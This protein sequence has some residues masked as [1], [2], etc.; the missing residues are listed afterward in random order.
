MRAQTLEDPCTLLFVFVCLGLFV[1]LLHIL[2]SVPSHPL[3][4]PLSPS[5]PFCTFM[6]RSPDSC[7]VKGVGWNA[8]CGHVS[9]K[10]LWAI[11]QNVF[12]IYGYSNQMQIFLQIFSHCVVFSLM[13]WSNGLQ[14]K[15][16]HT[17]KP[18]WLHASSQQ[19]KFIC[20]ICNKNA[21]RLLK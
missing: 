10:R 16:S 14:P 1:T 17:K 4:L 13:Q 19:L 9:N 2:G 7:R 20:W 21:A 15:K 12:R 6:F 11:S 18:I 8:K 3:P 5:P